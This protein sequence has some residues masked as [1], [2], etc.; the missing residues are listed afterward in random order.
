MSI[1]DMRRNIERSIIRR[2]VVGREIEP[3]AVVSDADVR[4]EYELRKG[5]FA[6]PAQVRLQEILVGTDQIDTR[7][8]AQDLVNRARAGEDFAA[9]A[10]ENSAAP[11]RGDGGDLGKLT[12]MALHSDVRSA[13]ESL[14][15]GGI[16]DPLAGADGSYRIF[17]V[18]ER[19]EEG[20]TPFDDVK[21]DLRKRLVDT[22]MLAEYDKLLK[23]LR[24]KA[25]IDVRVREVP[26]QVQVPT[27]A[28]ILD[29]PSADSAP[30]KVE[31]APAAADDAEFVV[32]P[33]AAPE[34][35]SPD[36]VPTPDP[37]QGQPPSP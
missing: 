18:S 13:V 9:L 16:S 31:A 14:P 7:A 28:S 6:H 37:S 4:A 8:K 35:T 22:R 12:L 23:E 24:E 15:V 25:I 34:R 30:A 36:A 5:E 2:Q 10:R 3:K 26:L 17:R 19:T 32:S 27:T 33:Q 20:L 29:P 21:A 1:D 11:T